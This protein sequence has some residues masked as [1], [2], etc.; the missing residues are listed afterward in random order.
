M[1]IQIKGCVKFLL[2][3]HT[4][5]PVAVGLHIVNVAEVVL[6]I[7]DDVTDLGHVT[8]YLAHRKWIPKG[9]SS[10]GKPEVAL[11][12]RTSSFTTVPTSYLLTFDQQSNF[13]GL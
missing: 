4:L 1:S 9:S 3:F 6:V 12:T 7:R 5:E 8:P 2:T 10:S 11:P 13:F